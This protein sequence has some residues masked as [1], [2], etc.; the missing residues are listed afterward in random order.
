MQAVTGDETETGVDWGAS[1]RWQGFITDEEK[2]LLDFAPV[3][4]WVGRAAT[5]VKDLAFTT[6]T[7]AQER[8]SW[9]TIAPAVPFGVADA[10]VW[11][12]FGEGQQLRASATDQQTM[13]PK[14]T[15]SGVASLLGSKEIGTMMTDM[16]TRAAEKHIKKLDQEINKIVFKVASGAY[17]DEQANAAM[18]KLVEVYNV[19]PEKVWNK[20]KT[21]WMHENFTKKEQMQMK[22]TPENLET[23]ENWGIINTEDEQ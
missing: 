7:E 2:G 22:V 9:K 11:D 16:Q 10:L 3:I 4:K 15:S 18:Q 1:N 12:S 23:Y 21:L 8:Q 17:T 14:T 20:A 6:Q 5:A 19:N 13:G